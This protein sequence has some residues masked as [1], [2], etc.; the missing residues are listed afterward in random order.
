MGLDRLS[1]DTLFSEPPAVA[2][3]FNSDLSST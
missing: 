2:L 1:R 3:D